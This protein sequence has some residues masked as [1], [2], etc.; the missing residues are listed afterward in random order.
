[1]KP[2]YCLPIIKA[3][4][5]EVLELVKA[6]LSDYSYLEVWLDYV[7]GADEAFVARL[8]DLL[9]KS[10]V[11]TFRRQNLEEPMMPADRRQ[12][13]IGALEGTPAL[14][15]LDVATQQAELDHIKRAEVQVKLLASYHN[16]ARTPDTLQLRQIIDTMDAYRPAVYKLST[17]CVNEGDALRL[18]ELLLELKARGVRAVVSGMGEH[19]AVTRIFGALWGNEMV[20]APLTTDGRSAPGQLTRAQ[21]ETIFKELS[22]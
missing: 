19:G 22:K 17:L 1:M 18:M 8:V 16:Y 13:L 14:V 21:L 11:V 5:T 7:Q 6:N 12:R 4:K 10:L 15:D 3:D 20:F 9:G 2:K